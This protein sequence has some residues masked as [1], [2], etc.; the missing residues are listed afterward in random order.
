[1]KELAERQRQINRN[2]ALK[3][4]LDPDALSDKFPP[5]I[6]TASKYERQVDRRT[7][8]DKKGLFEGVSRYLKYS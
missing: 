6:L 8:G 5:K 2:K 4:G 3:K 1:M 7:F